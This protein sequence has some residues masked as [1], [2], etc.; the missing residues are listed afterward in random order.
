[1]VERSCGGEVMWWRGHVVDR[2]CDG[3]V[4]WCRGH[5]VE[6]S[7]GVEVMCWRGH[8]VERSC[9]V[10]AMWWKCH[11]VERSAGACM[12]FACCR[13]YSMVGKSTGGAQQ[14]SLMG[15]CAKKGTAMHEMLHV[16]GFFHEQSRPD[17]DEWVEIL[18]QNVS[19]GTLLTSGLERVGGNCDF[20]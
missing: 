5:A 3:E 10:E 7:C 1:M 9:G 14:L 12:L 4:K 8:V 11:V 19:P 2:S 6:R 15:P 16:L 20:R 18:L 13:C 17:R